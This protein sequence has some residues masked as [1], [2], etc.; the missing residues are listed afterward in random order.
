MNKTELVSKVAENTGL[1]K[2]QV[3]LAVDAILTSIRDS[4]NEDENVNL[5]G[6]GTIYLRQMESRTARNPRT[7]Q[8]LQIPGKK[9]IRFRYSKNLKDLLNILDQPL[10]DL[11]EPSGPGDGEP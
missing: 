6:L 2:K 7:G 3:A 5:Q 1:S 11:N 8:K 10:L 4:L 9:A